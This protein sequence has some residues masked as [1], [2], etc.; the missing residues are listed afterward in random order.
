MHARLQQKFVA[1]EGLIEP[2]GASRFELER[3]TDRIGMVRILDV[4]TDLTGEDAE[5][6][7]DDRRVER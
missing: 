7:C 1:V 6:L 5:L 4:A 2:A 3:T